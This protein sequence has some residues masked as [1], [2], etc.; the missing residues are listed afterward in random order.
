VG[1]TNLESSL[2][3]SLNSQT[4][5]LSTSLL[6]GV[7]ALPTTVGV[8]STQVVFSISNVQ[9]P[10]SITT[11][12]TSIL[13]YI[14]TSSKNYIINQRTTGLTITNT[15]AG[16]I[17]NATA[18]P[19]DSS[20][21][22]TTSYLISFKPDNSI[23]QNTEVKVTIPSEVG[24]DTTTTMTCT[25]LLVIEN[26]L[27]CTY[28][29]TSKIVSI[30]S[31]FISKSTYVSSQIQFKISNLINPSTAITTSSFVIETQDSSGNLYNSISSGVTYTKTCNS[32]CL[33][34]ETDLTTCTSCNSSSS[35]SAFLSGGTC[36]ASCPAGE[37]DL[38][39][40]C[41]E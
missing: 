1:I 33:T 14:L 4:I 20:L 25:E 30:S 35:T 19:D 41:S 28:D 7:T 16:S 18:S 40:V 21:G 10:L 24:V 29:S 3:C 12:A 15:A 11:T 32:P 31:G 23:L 6:T 39:N 27:T 22:V 2:T 13:I 36:V 34:C 5:D 37:Y 26:T 38:S 17:S 9:N 8:T